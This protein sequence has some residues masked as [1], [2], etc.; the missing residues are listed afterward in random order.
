MVEAAGLDGLDNH[1][2]TSVRRWFDQYLSNVGTG[3]A[4]EPPVV[5]CGYASPARS[6]GT[7]TGRMSAPQP[8]TSDSR[9]PAHRGPGWTPRPTPG[10]AAAGLEALTGAPPVD[11]LPS[12]SRVDGAVWQGAALPLGAAIRGIRRLHLAVPSAPA[13]GTRVAYLYDVDL[14]RSAVRRRSGPNEGRR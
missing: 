11:R 5:C 14:D 9:R 7:R 1:V 13:T 6:S 3:I 12:V 4:A 2:R 10:C 8:S